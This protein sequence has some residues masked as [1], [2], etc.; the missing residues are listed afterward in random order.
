M[1]LIFVIS[2]LEY[3]S[4]FN[5]SY[6]LMDRAWLAL[7]TVYMTFFFSPNRGGEMFKYYIFRHHKMFCLST[8]SIKGPCYKM[9]VRK[10]ITSSFSPCNSA[11]ND[12]FQVVLKC[13]K[14]EVYGLKNWPLRLYSIIMY[15]STYDIESKI[16]CL[17]HC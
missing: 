4:L 2:F 12:V 9:I 13:S 3:F 15:P 1:I 10:V 6:I 17:S 5:L 7:Q 14:A 16:R 11:L 8:I